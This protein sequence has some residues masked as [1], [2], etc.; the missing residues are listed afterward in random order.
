[1]AQNKLVSILV[2]QQRWEE[3]DQVLQE[4]L[5][6]IRAAGA[7]SG[8]FG[9]V[10]R[11]AEADMAS[12]RGR[13][14]EA[15]S[16]TRSLLSEIEKT[17]GSNHKNVRAALNLLAVS[18][19]MQG[20]TSDAI[21]S[22]RRALQLAQSQLSSDHYDVLT[23]RDNLASALADAGDRLEA[24]TLRED[25]L[26][27]KIRTLGEQHPD[28]LLSAINLAEQYVEDDDAIRGGELADK[29]ALNA[30]QVFGAD[31]LFALEAREIGARARLRLGETKR[32]L[33]ELDG[34]HGTKRKILGEEDVYTLRSAG[35][36]AAAFS[37]SGNN[38]AALALLNPAIE[39]LRTQFGDDQHDLLRMRAQVDLASKRQSPIR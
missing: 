18:Q 1:M 27:S 4:A 39:S 17:Y 6:A 3:A 24:R 34:I 23:I 21:V 19:R 36:L 15:E 14:N 7:E 12:R 32:A 37:A 28:T 25:V 33:L 31:H 29:A 10:L 30:R 11:M 5:S 26:S 13:F 20:K 9:I 35:F 16:L 22:L 38:V 8:S 2:R